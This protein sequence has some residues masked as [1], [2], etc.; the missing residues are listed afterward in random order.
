MEQNKTKTMKLKDKKTLKTEKKAEKL[1]AKKAAKQQK[2]PKKA[3]AKAIKKAK[4]EQARKANA[5]MK[6]QLKP[7]KT[8]AKETTKEVKADEKALK[9]IKTQ[10]GAQK[11]ATKSLT[12]KPEKTKKLSATA[13]IYDDIAKAERESIESDKDA[14]IAKLEKENKKIKDKY[15]YLTKEKNCGPKYQSIMILLISIIALLFGII[16]TAI[17]IAYSLDSPNLNQ[18][19][20]IICM[21]VFF[22]L[23][24][25]TLSAVTGL[26]VS[27]CITM[28]KE[29]TLTILMVLLMGI[30]WILSVFFV[31]MYLLRLLASAG[32]IAQV[33]EVEQLVIAILLLLV[34]IIDIVC[35]SILYLGVKKKYPDVHIKQK[36]VEIEE[37]K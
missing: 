37:V 35:G 28:K 5:Q 18:N 14:R 15:S 7:E 17:Y 22:S 19:D 25:L 16:Y 30:I 34:P 36:M 12:D 2:A 13:K 6:T 20:A 1:A 24:L 9:D 29:H 32:I 27:L 11:L 31:V 33:G 23:T 4:K 8:T 26:A 21:T 10:A 3:E